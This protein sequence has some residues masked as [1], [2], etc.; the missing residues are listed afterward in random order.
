MASKPEQKK[1]YRPVGY[2]S[3]GIDDMYYITRHV[4]L[5]KPGFTHLD[6]ANRHISNYD[7]KEY[8]SKI[9]RTNNTL[10]SIDLSNSDI[11]NKGA[12]HIKEAL[13]SNTTL[14]EIIFGI[15]EI[16]IK[17]RNSIQEI[18]KKRQN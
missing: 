16:S 2:G 4:E 9:I 17:K 13:K 10:I 5:E 7:A 8:I 11:S 18:L 15:S 3:L 14:R 1:I 6:L 12:R